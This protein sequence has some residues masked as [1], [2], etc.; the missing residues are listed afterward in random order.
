MGEEWAYNGVKLDGLSLA[1]Y[2]WKTQNNCG[3]VN[4]D[5]Y[6]HI[7]EDPEIGC[8]TRFLFKRP[9]PVCFSLLSPLSLWS[10][11]LSSL[12]WFITVAS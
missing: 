11:S 5:V 9:N 3:L 12:T 2:N 1:A 7:K 8:L 10:Q 4:I 6:F